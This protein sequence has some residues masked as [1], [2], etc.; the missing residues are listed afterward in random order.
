MSKEQIIN[1]SGY[2]AL[3]TSTEYTIEISSEGLS[4]ERNVEVIFYND[5]IEMNCTDSKLEEQDNKFHSEACPSMFYKEAQEALRILE[6][7][8]DVISVKITDEKDDYYVK[9]EKY[10]E[11]SSN[12]IRFR[13][14]YYEFDHDTREWN[15]S[16][17]LE[18]SLHMAEKF[19]EVLIKMIENADF[20]LI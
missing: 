17:E 12:Y 4:R 2:Q 18:M 16:E 5:L 13:R 20:E 6:A 10:I 8:V 14:S 1:S 3:Y 9:V 11:E 7:N 15:V 19:Y